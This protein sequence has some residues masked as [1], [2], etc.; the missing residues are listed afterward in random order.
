MAAA[1]SGGH[2][3]HTPQH[4]GVSHHTPT[5]GLTAPVAPPMR[6]QAAPLDTLA[7]CTA[8]VAV[9][10]PHSWPLLSASIAIVCQPA[11]TTQAN[12]G[13][14]RATAAF[15]A[16]EV[17]SCQTRQGAP[18]PPLPGMRPPPPLQ[19][20][21]ADPLFEFSPGPGVSAPPAGAGTAGSQQQDDGLGHGGER[22]PRELTGTVR[23]KVQELAAAV[24][25]AVDR[26]PGEQVVQCL[27]LPCI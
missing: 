11:W 24:V 2:T 1:P 18:Q 9:F 21:T 4:R 15:A 8:C 6:H 27:L 10:W 17:A 25:D 26:T 3:G 12:G 16:R 22:G 19:I 14:C 23:L 5:A 20:I 7:L 13:P